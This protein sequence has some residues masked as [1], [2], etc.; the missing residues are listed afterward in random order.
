MQWDAQKRGFA[1]VDLDRVK[2]SPEVTALIP[3]ELARQLSV[4]PVK[5]KGNQAWVVMLD[6]DDREAR[7][8]LYRATG[9]E[10]VPVMALPEAIHWAIDCYYP[11]TDGVESESK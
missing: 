1:F 8:A 10:I 3:A 9:C 5:V 4:I 11:Q 2:V 6:P 7:D